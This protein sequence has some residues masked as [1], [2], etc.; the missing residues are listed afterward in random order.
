[1]KSR[2]RK[3]IRRKLLAIGP[4]EAAAKS[5][6]ACRT[7]AA[8]AEFKDAGAVMIYLPIPGE[9]DTAHLALTAFQQAKTVLVPKVDWTQRHMI[10]VTYRSLD[11]EMIEDKY[12]VRVPAAGEPWPVEDIDF[13]IVPA[14]GYDLRGHRLGRGGGFYDRFI[15]QPKM[16]ATTCGIAFEVQVVEQLPIDDHDQPIDML[17]TDTRTL[18]FEG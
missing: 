8:L 11:D 13:V 10:S 15:G 17:V 2:I 7:V 6:A 12:G 9:V 5:Q 18:R 1:M 14:L 4:D 16:R 3:E